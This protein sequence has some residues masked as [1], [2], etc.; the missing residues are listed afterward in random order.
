MKPLLIAAALLLIPVAAPSVALAQVAAGT[1]PNT[2]DGP[3]QP[4]A[5]APARPAAP[6]PATP[7]NPRSEDVLRAYIA[8]AQA[9][10]VDYSGMT[11]DVATRLRGQEAVNLPLIAGFGPVQAV[12]FLG[13]HNGNDVYA[14][15]FATEATEW[16]IGFNEAG[17]VA[18][19]L[20]RKAE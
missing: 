17:K 11:D 10:A 15:T 3:A 16:L 12:D 1:M 8:G 18:A 5:V 9:G 13:V 14:V 2:F 4:R 7:A 20:F 6:A 19:L